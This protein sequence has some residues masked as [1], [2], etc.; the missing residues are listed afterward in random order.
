MNFTTNIGNINL[1]CPI[2][3]ASGPNT[4]STKDLEQI[5]SSKSA[6]VLSKTC[7][8]EPI[9]NNEYSMSPP[10]NKCSI[11]TFELYNSNYGAKYYVDLQFT[12][13]YFISILANESSFEIIFDLIYNKPNVKSIE[14]NFA[15]PTLNIAYEASLLDNVLNKLFDIIEPIKPIGVK[16]PPFYSLAHLEQTIKVICKY[17][18]AYIAAINSINNTVICDNEY[19]TLLPNNGLNLDIGIRH[20]ALKN[21]R[22]IATLLNKHNRT[23]IDIVGVGGIFLGYD[24]FEMISYGAT[25]VQIGTCYS[26]EGP[27]C[28]ERILGELVE[29]MR[30]NGYTSIE[31]FRGKNKTQRAKL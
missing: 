31:Q 4:K 1:E 16:L 12:K 15:Y 17:P 18:I 9:I 21:I 22:M 24:V 26:L 30:K 7:T 2:Y 20:I 23:D 14:L 8:I 28:F 27:K 3:N 5:N 10:I 19:S 6:A 13:P 11:N 29:I 25:A